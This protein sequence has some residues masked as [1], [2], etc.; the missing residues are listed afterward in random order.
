VQSFKD[1]RAKGVSTVRAISAEMTKVAERLGSSEQKDYFIEACRSL[2][3]I[4]Q[5]SYAVIAC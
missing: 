5:V 3:D 4:P 2:N 1:I